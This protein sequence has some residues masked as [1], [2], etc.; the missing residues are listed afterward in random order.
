MCITGKALCNLGTTKASVSLRPTATG[1][2]DRSGSPTGCFPLSSS[3]EICGFTIM[4]T[5]VLDAATKQMLPLETSCESAR[6]PS[7]VQLLTVFQLPLIKH[8]CVRAPR[9]RGEWVWPGGS[10]L[11]VLMTLQIWKVPQ[12][13][14]LKLLKFKVFCFL[15]DFQN[16]FQVEGECRGKRLETRRASRDLKRY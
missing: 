1:S 12:M 10:F 4:R 14:A 16:F 15:L 13:E 9:L 6:T 8:S 2:R 7:Q 5:S 11:H 3:A